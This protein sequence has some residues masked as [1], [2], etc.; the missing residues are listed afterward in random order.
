MNSS[1]N[2]LNI[3]NAE[4]S[5]MANQHTHDMANAA[6]EASLACQTRALVENIRPVNTNYAYLPKQEK[7]KVNNC[8]ICVHIYIYLNFK[9]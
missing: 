4:S 5:R 7:F 6:I 3:N 2:G 9:F 8:L 1:N